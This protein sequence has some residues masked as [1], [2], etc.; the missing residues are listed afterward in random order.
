MMNRGRLPLLIP[1]VMALFVLRLAEPR[2]GIY[3][4]AHAGGDHAH[5]HAAET[6]GWDDALL[7]LHSHSHPHSHPQDH[8]HVHAVA[9][10]ETLATPALPVPFTAGPRLTSPGEHS[11]AHWHTQS[12]FDRS[13]AHSNL[14]I[15]TVRRSEPLAD[16]GPI[17]IDARPLPQVL[18]RGPPSFSSL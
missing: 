1:A 8:D 11:G 7:D 6:S 12:V 13:L 5:V 17:T 15:L 3:F 9:I 10:A 4:H 2:P 16:A 14:T 18:A